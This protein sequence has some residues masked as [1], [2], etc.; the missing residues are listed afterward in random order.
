MSGELGKTK[1]AFTYEEQLAIIKGVRALYGR[2]EI[3]VQEVG[4]IV[5]NLPLDD[6]GNL[7][8][9]CGAP[10]DGKLVRRIGEEL[11]AGPLD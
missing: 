2:S 8:L 5:A 4:R 1:F 7:A 6:A 11:A 3:P 10:A 9:L